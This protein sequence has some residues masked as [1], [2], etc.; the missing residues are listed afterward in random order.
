M[1]LRDAKIALIEP[2]KHEANMLAD[3][4][5]MAGADKI[6][7]YADC[8]EAMSGLE[9]YSATVILI[10]E[11]AGPSGAVAWTRQFRRSHR[12]MNRKAPVFV[13]SRQ[14]SR[15]LAEN[16]RHGGVNALIG[17]PMSSAVLI[18]T[19]KKVLAKPR[20]FI[21]AEN[22]VGP[23]R[24]AGIVT[25]G[26]PSKRRKSDEDTIGHVDALAA[27]AAVFEQ[28]AKNALQDGTSLETCAAPLQ[29]LRDV[30]AKAGDGPM[31][32]A[33]AS[34]ALLL[35][36]REQGAF[37]TMGACVARISTLAATKPD[38]QA[39]RDALAEDIRQAV[40]HIATAVAA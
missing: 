14:M 36:A 15:L 37:A 5:R 7:R 8:T 6:R 21:D 33:C 24:R 19:I 20:P 13:L 1:E 27:A 16:C 12:V 10:D 39:A 31:M 3:M 4:L 35:T 22:Y 30:A 40:A 38:E 17:K 11:E 9:V 34:A 29:A 2:N 26:L 23:C 32:R 28:A 25:A 18:A